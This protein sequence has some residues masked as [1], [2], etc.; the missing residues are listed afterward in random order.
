MK[1]VWFFL[2][3]FLAAIIVAAQDTSYARMVDKLYT[4]YSGQVVKKKYKLDKVS[5]DVG[6]YK[7]TKDLRYMT[8]W[9]DTSL[10]KAIIFFFEGDKIVMISPIGQQPYFIK[11]GEMVF[12]AQPNHT[13]EEIQRFLRKG[14]SYKEFALSKY[15]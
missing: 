10:P 14:Y 15:R 13:R 3:C 5:V 7:N 6:F 4:N 8:V 9:K 11:D 12:A 2:I 1:H